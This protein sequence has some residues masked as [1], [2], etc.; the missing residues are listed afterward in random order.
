MRLLAEEFM[1]PDEQ[2]FVILAAGKIDSCRVFN[3]SIPGQ[4]LSCQ[5]VLDFLAK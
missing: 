3:S 2:L 5:Q 4:L 1:A